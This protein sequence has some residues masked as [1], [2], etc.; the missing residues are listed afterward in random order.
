MT[1]QNGKKLV[2][3]NS[4]YT[5][6]LGATIDSTA[7]SIAGDLAA[8]S[9]N[10][11]ES[12][13]DSFSGAG[14]TFMRGYNTARDEVK[15]AGDRLGET[16]KANPLLAVAIAAGAGFALASLFTLSNSK[17]ARKIS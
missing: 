13:K 4:D 5:S 1:T 8:K 9:S 17:K 15:V 10:F 11:M 6:D 2:S 14:D 3:E 7:T 16:V 12:A